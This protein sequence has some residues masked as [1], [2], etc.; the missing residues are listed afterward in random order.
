MRKLTYRSEYNSIKNEYGSINAI[1][2]MLRTPITRILGCTHLLNT[3]DLNAKQKRYTQNIETS[4]QQL[5]SII[6]YLTGELD[7]CQQAKKRQR[8]IPKQQ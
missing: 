3:G 5:L 7:Q 2:H 4:M 8:L 1:S 6:D